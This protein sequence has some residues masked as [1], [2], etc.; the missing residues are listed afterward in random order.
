MYSIRTKTL[1]EILLHLQE[2]VAHQSYKDFQEVGNRGLLKA[3]Q[4]VKLMIQE[5]ET[6]LQLCEQEM[7]CGGLGLHNLN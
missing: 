6:L 3:I 2:A 7:S 4:K 5:E 1:E